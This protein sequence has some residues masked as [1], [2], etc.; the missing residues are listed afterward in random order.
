LSHG[1]TLIAWATEEVV[2]PDVCVKEERL[3]QYG[4]LWWTYM[5]TSCVQTG[6][7]CSGP[8]GTVFTHGSKGTYYQYNHITGL[9]ENGED[10][11]PREVR[12][13]LDGVRHNSEAWPQLFHFTYRVCE[14]VAP[15]IQ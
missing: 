5:F 4:S 7:S 9:P 11:C 3:C 12:I 8:D 6:Q 1:D 14:V 10:V 13:C 15:E 2:Y